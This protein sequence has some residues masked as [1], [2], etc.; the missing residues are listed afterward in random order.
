MVPTVPT[1]GVKIRKGIVPCTVKG[2]T[3]TPLRNVGQKLVVDLARVDTVVRPKGIPRCHGAQRIERSTLQQTDPGCSRQL[4]K[5]SAGA[6]VWFCYS[7]AVVQSFECR[8]IVG[9]LRGATIAPCKGP[10]PP[11]CFTSFE[12]QKTMKSTSVQGT[13]L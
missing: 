1:W 3:T 8:D 5:I 10:G 4:K 6:R 12:K 9:C 7:S 2:R 11:T 13:I